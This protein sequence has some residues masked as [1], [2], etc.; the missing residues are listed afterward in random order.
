[1]GVSARPGGAKP[2]KRSP[3]Y[4]GVSLKVAIERAEKVY[5]KYENHP[6]PREDVM[7]LWG[8]SPGS[9]PGLVSLGALKKFGLLV[10]HGRGEGSTVS[11]TEKAFAYFDDEREDQSERE[12]FIRETALVPTIHQEI[13]D[14]YG[15]SP[16][17]DVLKHWLK[18]DKSFTPNGADSLISEY[19][20]TMAFAKIGESG[21]VSEDEGDETPD[22]G[23]GAHEARN[24]P[25]RRPKERAM[26]DLQ[27]ESQDLTI[28]IGGGQVAILRAPAKITA[29]QYHFLTTYFTAMK[30][31]IITAP[32]ETPEPNASDDEH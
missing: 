28:P 10:A 6:M 16:K 3:D 12:A 23:A 18:T 21:T 19:L 14:R 17:I 9:G 5:A 7:A 27:Q 24:P 22:A 30:D 15:V 31:A 26:P 32:I 1:M 8:Y 2:K 25:P 4:P 29:Q 11:L 20:E 13:F